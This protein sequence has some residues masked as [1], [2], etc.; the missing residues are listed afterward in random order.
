MSWD[1]WY[2]DSMNRK[3]FDLNNILIFFV[4]LCLM[5]GCKNSVEGG[6]TGIPEASADTAVQEDTK[7]EDIEEQQKKET[8]KESGQA[9]NYGEYT[10]QELEFTRDGMKI[11]GRLY[12]PAGEG[13][14]PIAVM[15]H[16]FG[17]NLSMMEGYAI[18]FARNG[19]AAYAFDFIGGGHGI[20]SD[21]KMTEM[22]VLTEAADMNAVLDGIRLLDL[23]DKNNIFA[24]GGSQGGFVATYIAGTRPDDI[25]GLIALYPAYV[26]QD[27]S[28]KRTKDGTE[29]IDTF[30]VMGSTISRLYDED[31]L[32]F[33]IYDV[34]KGFKG[35]ALLIH[36]TADPVVPYSYSERAVE[37]L[38]SAKLITINGA[39]HGFGGKDDVYA[40]QCAIDF[41]KEEAGMENFDSDG[42]EDKMNTDMIR[43]FTQNSIRIDAGAGI[44]Y[45]DPVKMREESHDADYILITHD[46]YDHY[47]PEDILKVCK[48]STVLVVP[49]SMESEAGELTDSVDMIYTVEPDMKK[50]VS[51]LEIETVPAYNNTKSFHPKNAGWV[52]Y[53]LNVDGMRIY[54]A[55]DTD[56]NNDNKTV[57]CDVAMIPI[58]GTYTM[59]AAQAA[60][61]VN[62]IKPKTA[63]PT[64]YGSFVGSPG[65]ADTFKAQVDQDIDVEIKMEY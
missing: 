27:D 23:V 32:S 8:A 65:D 12:L 30:S 24:M 55:G 42:K 15:G 31:A 50:T 35:D 58:G 41:I 44:I 25:K 49:E 3:F 63:I 43:L 38:P 6:G 36:G 26:L 33:D 57:K 9:M 56:M 64:H 7:E 59:D 48:D 60:Q 19:I 20:K 45:I 14:F 17:A 2:N 52:G 21:G 13:P 47:S 46:H 37:T 11:Y 29:F 62:Q 4:L 40:T 54:I 61:F 39:G 34:M 18:S 53:I 1:I 10:V 22:S 51:G 16:G 5:S 28:R